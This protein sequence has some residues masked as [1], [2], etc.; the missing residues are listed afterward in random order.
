[1]MSDRYCIETEGKYSETFA[2]Q[3]MVDCANSTW[4]AEGCDGADTQ[5]SIK[6]IAEYGLR[7][8]D[9]YPY[10]SGDTE[11]NGTCFESICPSGMYVVQYNIDHESVNLHYNYS[12]VEMAQDI[13]E[14][15]PIYLSMVVFSDFKAYK[16]GV[17]APLEYEVLGTHAIK[18]LGWGWD[19]GLQTYYWVC[20]NSWTTSWGEEGFFRI[21]FNAHIGYL[22]GSARHGTSQ[23]SNPFI[24]I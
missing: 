5:T 20:A 9:C 19:E 4:Q 8:E 17:Y 18:C 7:T 10:F 13:K 11:T 6:W 12:N 16:G 14:H 3:Y 15:G 24:S 1:M 23:I 22:G 2:P 21:A